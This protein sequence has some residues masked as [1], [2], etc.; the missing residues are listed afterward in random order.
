[1][2]RI[3]KPTLYSYRKEG[4]IKITEFTSNGEIIKKGK[5]PP[6]RCVLNN[7][8]GVDIRVNANRL[9]CRDCG[10]ELSFDG[11]I[12]KLGEVPPEKCPVCNSLDIRKKN[13]K[14]QCNHCGTIISLHLKS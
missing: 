11:L 1:M 6:N 3:S 12:I 10:T 9:R 2:L 5:K 8:D 13:E 4:F 14:F 7:C